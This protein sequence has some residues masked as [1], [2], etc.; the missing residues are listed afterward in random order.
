MRQVFI[1]YK[2]V[3]MEFMKKIQSDE[4]FPIHSLLCATYENF[5]EILLGVRLNPE[6]MK[7]YRK[8][9]PGIFRIEYGA[10]QLLHKAFNNDEIGMIGKIIMNQEKTYST[11]PFNPIQLNSLLE[12]ASFALESNF[13]NPQEPPQKPTRRLKA[14]ILYSAAENETITPW[15]DV[16]PSLEKA[17]ISPSMMPK[18]EIT[19]ISDKIY[20]GPD[21]ASIDVGD[22]QMGGHPNEE[23]F[24]LREFTHK[25]AK[26]RPLPE[27]PTNN[28]VQILETI[29][30]MVKEDYS[31]LDIG[32]TIEVARDNIRKITLH[33]DFM[34]EMGKYANMYSKSEPQ[35]A[36]NHKEKERFLEVVH[37]W[38]KTAKITNYTKI[39]N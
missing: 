32:K 35:I 12:S 29:E 14:A 13:P 17:E 11:L 9:V 37:E 27:I 15:P 30:K 33:T 24:E 3:I 4:T 7:H 10:E 39:D 5:D 23:S 22:Y 18:S 31:I 2:E 19:G 28:I 8:R 36:F 25:K 26:S 34:F 6:T 20:E 21:F 1:P 38:V 16:I